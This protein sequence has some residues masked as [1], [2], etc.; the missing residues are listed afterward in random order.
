MTGVHGANRLASNSLLEAVV[1]GFRASLNIKEFL[2]DK[3][4][5][6]PEIPDWDD[7]GTLSA[8]EKVLITHSTR[9]VKTGYVGLCRYCSGQTCVL[10]ERQ[11][12]FIIS[13]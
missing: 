6:T 10:N 5:N 7:S 12:E 3:D 1:F 9:E 4:L 8:D 13:S 11:E 2:N